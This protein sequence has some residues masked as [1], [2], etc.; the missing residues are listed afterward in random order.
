DGPSGPGQPERGR[1]RATESGGRD[2][3]ADSEHGRHR[4]LQQRSGRGVGENGHRPAHRHRS[5]EA[6]RSTGSG[7]GGSAFGRSG[8]TL[9]RSEC[10]GKDAAQTAYGDWKSSLRGAQAH[11][12]AGIRHDQ[13][14]ARDPQ[15]SVA[16]P[17]ESVGRVATDLLDPQSFE[18]LAPLLQRRGRLRGIVRAQ[19]WAEAEKAK[20]QRNP[21]AMREH[22]QIFGQAPSG[23]GEPSFIRRDPHVEAS[24]FAAEAERRSGRSLTPGQ[25]SSFWMS[26][27]LKHWQEAPIAS[28]RFLGFKIGLLLND[29][30]IPDSQSIDWVRLAAAPSLSLAFLSFGWLAPWA[31]L[32][33]TRTQ[34]SSFWWFL[35]AT[36]VVGLGSTAIF[37]VLGRY[38]VPWAPGLALLAAAWMVDLVRRLAERQWRQVA[39]RILLVAVP[40]A[41]LSWRPEVDPDPD[42]WGYFQLALLVAYA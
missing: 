27:G 8:S 29:L 35:A 31:A 2:A 33:L 21:A 10:E 38:R 15:V 26:E 20:A 41:A 25:V 11:R 4:L 14:R 24:D 36:T 40:V 28:L 22:E 13:V 1:D 12:R 39:W 32:G 34:R 37:F 23:V 7:R 30:E 6:P 9:G 16:R 5:T 19:G 42:R 18:D 17:G 3:H